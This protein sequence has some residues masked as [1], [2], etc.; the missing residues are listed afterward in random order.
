MMTSRTGA[1]SWCRGGHTQVGGGGGSMM[2][3]VRVNRGHGGVRG[4]GAKAG[5]SGG[6]PIVRRGAVGGCWPLIRG[7]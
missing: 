7:G 3:V 5:G 1:V 6:G 2:M 4:A